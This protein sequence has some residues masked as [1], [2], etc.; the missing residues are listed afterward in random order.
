[1]NARTFV[2]ALLLLPATA[3]AQSQAYL[4]THGSK[5]RGHGDSDHSQVVYISVPRT[6]TGK[7]QKFKLV[8]AEKNHILIKIL[9]V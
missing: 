9:N 2:F 7:L 6:A 3:L 1:M 5:A 4:V 8:K